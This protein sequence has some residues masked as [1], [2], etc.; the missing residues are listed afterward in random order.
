MYAYTPG[1]DLN[2][3]I[4]TGSSAYAAFLTPEEWLGEFDAAYVTGLD[5]SPDITY[6]I[7]ADYGAGW[8]S[9]A[10]TATTWPYGDLDDSGDAD[11]TDLSC[12]MDCFQGIFGGPG[13]NT[14][15]YSCDIAGGQTF[16]MPDAET[17]FADISDELDAYKGYPYSCNDPCD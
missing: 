8:L 10:A 5:L 2:I 4:L 12:I 14:T 15:E 11:M 9:E 13:C 6:D 16:C 1:G 3:S 17:D 7:E